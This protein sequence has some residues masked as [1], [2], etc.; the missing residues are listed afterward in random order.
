MEDVFFIGTDIGGTTFSSAIFDQ[1]MKLITTSEKGFITEFSD[2]G[3]F[4]DA[5]KIQIESIS[6]GKHVVYA[7]FACPG[8]LNSKEGK[9]LDTPNLTL[10]QNCD[11]KFE[12]EKRLSIPCRVEND[13][14][15]FALGEWQNYHEKKDVFVG[16]TLGT[17]LGFGVIIN[18]K[19]YTGG[20][21]M[22]AEYGVSPFLDGKWESEISIGG[23]QIV[24]LQKLGKKLTPLEL[25]ESANQGNE[26]ALEIWSIFGERLGQCLSH[27]INM[28]D[29]NAISIGGGIAHAFKH[30]ENGM[31]KQIK[32]HSPSYNHNSIKIFES[33]EKEI[34][35]MRGAAMLVL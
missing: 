6:A 28:L 31:V 27:V 19:I 3:S 34:S 11:L 29:P 14:N 7:G 30:F 12:M 13:A 9:I 20:N 4:L 18:G 21:G 8:P 17:G 10:L 25:N 24:C 23:I 5:V 35:A 1:N 15:L 22:A 2:T 32:Q 33:T 26:I 16:V